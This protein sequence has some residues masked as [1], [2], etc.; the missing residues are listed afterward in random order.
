MN[1]LQK[2]QALYLVDEARLNLWIHEE[3]EF[4]AIGGERQ[5]PGF[6]QQLKYETGKS[7]AKPG[8]SEHQKLRAQ[9]L[10]FFD[11]DGKWMQVPKMGAPG[12]LNHKAMLQ[13]I[14]DYWESLS[15]GLNYWGGNFTHIYDPGHFERRER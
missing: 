10:E 6:V 1:Q 9:D 4:T 11:S 3:S 15:P 5:R 13:P 14:G 12:Q 2:S 8:Q 7:K